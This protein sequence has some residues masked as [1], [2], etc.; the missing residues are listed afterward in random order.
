MRGTCPVRLV[1]LVNDFHIDCATVAANL[2]SF[3]TVR[4]TFFLES[5][6]SCDVVLFLHNQAYREESREVRFAH[7]S[8]HANSVRLDFKDTSCQPQPQCNI[9]PLHSVGINHASKYSDHQ[10][11]FM[12]A[13][14]S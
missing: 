12:D 11:I 1:S 6:A 2:R 10:Q 5:L 3:S 4:V 14:S 7:A 13:E 8:S 9:L